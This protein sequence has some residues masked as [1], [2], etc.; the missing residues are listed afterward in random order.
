MIEFLDD[1]VRKTGP[2]AAVAV[3]FAKTRQ[4]AAVGKQT[5]AFYVPEILSF[6]PDAG[7]LEFE[8]LHG[9][10]RM[11]QLL[12]DLHP[13]LDGLIERAGRALAIIHSHLHLEET[14][15][16]PFPSEW[17][18]GNPDCAFLH[19]DYC[20][21]N[22]G[23]DDPTGR[24]VI[25]DWAPTPYLKTNSTFGPRYFDM[26]W[27]VLSTYQSMAATFRKEWAADRIADTFLK[28][29]LDA[30][31]ETLSRHLFRD[32]QHRVWRLLSS[33]KSDRLARRSWYRRPIALVREYLTLARF[34]LYRPGKKVWFPR[35]P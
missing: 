13:S 32:F 4:A 11:D 19:G 28:A 3:E 31:T 29:Y 33:G 2:P 24:L 16:I 20:P 6:D 26:T 17:M 18:A 30:R 12:F 22:I 9:F 21:I 35:G 1:R 27:F 14:R 7:V 25:L 15:R 5:G 23:L 34:E 10:R 8:R